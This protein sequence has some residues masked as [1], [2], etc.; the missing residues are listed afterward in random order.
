[1]HSGAAKNENEEKIQAKNALR[2]GTVMNVRTAKIS[3]EQP[4]RTSA[5]EV[6]KVLSLKRNPKTQNGVIKGSS[7]SM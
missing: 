5:R 4:T 7:Y 3:R 1:M 2:E 6:R